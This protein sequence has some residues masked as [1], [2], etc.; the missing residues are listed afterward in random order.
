MN[1]DLNNYKRV[2]FYYS[3]QDLR[4]FISKRNQ[5]MGWILNFANPIS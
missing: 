1:D 3:T 2:I 4:I 5:W